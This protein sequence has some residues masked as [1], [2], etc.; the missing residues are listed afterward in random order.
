[1]SKK[2]ASK[3]TAVVVTVDRLV[4]L[5]ELNH[6]KRIAE[7]KTQIPVL[8]HVRLGATKGQLAIAVTDLDTTLQ[9]TLSAT[10]EGEGAMC[11]SVAQL[12]GIVKSLAPGDVRLT[13]Q[14]S[15][16]RLFIESGTARF[17]LVGMDA[18]NFPSLPSVDADGGTVEI[19]SEL[20]RR[21]IRSV[22]F[23]ISDDESRF[24][25]MGALL[26]VTGELV[27][28]VATDGHRVAVAEAPS[29][30]AVLVGAAESKV[31]VPRKAL[32]ELVKI[33][34]GVA[35]VEYRRN[36]RHIAFRCGRRDV[37][38]RILEGE[39]PDWRRVIDTLPVRVT[40]ER[41]HL[42]EAIARV[43]QMTGQENRGVRL[44]IGGGG[45]DIEAVNPDRGQA[46]EHVECKIAG[47]NGQPMQIAFNSD[48][49]Q[50]ALGATDSA[51]VALEMRDGESQGVF[52]PVEGDASM[53]HVCVVMPMH[54]EYP[55]L[56]W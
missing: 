13:M 51:A 46:S 1:M 14:D 3:G 9:T 36:D 45:I 27:S 32:V 19:D 44:R 20:L 42:C 33:S 26:A 38:A 41:R 28:L 47:S 43:E 5:E 56:E 39:F 48:Y 8:S 12:H 21:M 30:E 49:L 34:E 16:R 18:E 2:A 22:S 35:A 31:I 29:G 50:D 6:A 15:P 23:A 54:V 25:L 37:T 53:R 55:R 17:H 40:T 52:R 10:T 11:A 4:L 7:R 24:Q